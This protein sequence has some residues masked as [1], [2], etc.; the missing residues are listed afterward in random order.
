MDLQT[1]L[2]ASALA[3][4][5]AG[6]V[7]AVA[8]WFTAGDDPGADTYQL[9]VV[10]GKAY[11]IA[12]GESKMY[13]REVQRFGGKAGVLFDE[14]SRWFA[15]L[16]RGKSLALTVGWIAVLVSVGLFLLGWIQRR[17]EV[18]DDEGEGDRRG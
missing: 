11:P 3:V 9:V 4:L 7:V 8:I 10:D 12:P 13:V 14:I 18:P 6:L 5:I 15:R 2:Y 16:W 1:R 17:D